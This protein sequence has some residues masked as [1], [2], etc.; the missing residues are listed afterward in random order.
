MALHT[1]DTIRREL[2]M[3]TEA[4]EAAGVE[5]ATAQGKRLMRP[6]YG[7]VGPARCGC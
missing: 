3:T 2:R 4:I 7:R 5:M 1:D 6:P